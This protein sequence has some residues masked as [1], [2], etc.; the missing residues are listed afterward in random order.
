MEEKK[1]C[2]DCGHEFKQGESEYNYGTGN[3]DYECP[4]CGWCGNHTQVSEVEP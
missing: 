4:E 1:Y 3:T 2:P